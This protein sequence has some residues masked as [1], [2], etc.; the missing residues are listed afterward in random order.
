MIA[1]AHPLEKAQEGVFCNALR[2]VLFEPNARRKWSDEDECIHSEFLARAV[3]K[4]L[5]SDASRPEYKADGIGQDFIP[6]PRYRPGLVAES[7]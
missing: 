1:S 3:A 5:P 4:R 6:N 2:S 7:R